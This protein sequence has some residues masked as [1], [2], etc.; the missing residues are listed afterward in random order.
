MFTHV[1][2][3]VSTCHVSVGVT[4]ERTVQVGELLGRG[5]HLVL[6]RA[7]VIDRDCAR[8]RHVARQVEVL[9]GE[10]GDLHVPERVDAVVDGQATATTNGC[11]VGDGQ[12]PSR[13]S[14]TVYSSRLPPKSADVDGR[15]VRRA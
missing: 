9:I 1:L 7:P 15:S 12:L 11:R 4:V 14:V 8:G 13:L 10:L 2:A 5:E 3:A 6:G